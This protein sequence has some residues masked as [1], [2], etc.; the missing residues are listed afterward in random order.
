MTARG[1]RNNNPGNIE[2]AKNG[3]TWS[4]EVWPGDDKRFCTFQSMAWGCRAIM[5]TLRTYHKL[6]GL[7]TVEEIVGRWAPSNENNTQ[8]YALHVA[9]DI[10][11][12][13]DER[14][15]FDD[16]P[17]YYLAIAKAIAR[18]E[19]GPDAETISSDVW[20]EAYKLAEPLT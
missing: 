16:D 7:E 10:G 8:S 17:T 4:G 20:E 3:A 12:A 14:I 9:S 13:T 11:R 15:H 5:R 2:K 6:H 18:H 19:C 1:S